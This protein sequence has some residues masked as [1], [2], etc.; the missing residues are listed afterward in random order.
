MSIF[1]DC[2][3]V[4]FSA[5][6][7]VA[8]E[9]VE[10]RAGATILTDLTAVAEDKTEQKDE[11]GGN[12]ITSERHVQAFLIRASLLNFVPAKGHYIK[13]PN[14]KWYKVQNPN[15]STVW[16][17]SESNNTH[18]RIYTVEDPGP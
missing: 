3:S 5:I 17:W 7:D 14:G 8:G 15:G 18:Y 6:E 16:E 2:M 4:G 9:L 10:Y 1:G 12:R 13:R 11:I